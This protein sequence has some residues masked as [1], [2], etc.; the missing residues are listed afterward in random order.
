MKTGV[1]GTSHFEFSIFFAT[2]TTQLLEKSK[3]SNC[4]RFYYLEYNSGR[5]TKYYITLIDTVGKFGVTYM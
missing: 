2:F 4:I 3:H 5:G 1:C